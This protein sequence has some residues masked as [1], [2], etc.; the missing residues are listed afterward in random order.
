LQNEGDVPETIVV[1]RDVSK[2]ETRSAV[3]SQPGDI[4]ETVVISPQQLKGRRSDSNETEA[5]PG[6][7]PEQRKRAAPKATKEPAAKGK[8][9]N[10]EDEDEDLPK[11][12]ILDPSKTRK[13]P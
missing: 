7:V 8:P 12:V 2:A 10:V 9:I 4:P 3:E 13:E 1:G 6:E 11:T 5:S